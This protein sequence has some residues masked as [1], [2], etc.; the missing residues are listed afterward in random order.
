[1]ARRP[2]APLEPGWVVVGGLPVYHRAFVHPSAEAVPIVHVH[3]FGISGTYLEPTA[4]LLA[5]HHSCY[6]PDLPGMGRSLRPEQRLDLPG[7][8][9]A[10]VAYCDALGIDRAV[11][12]G[13]SLGCCLPA[14]AVPGDDAL[15]HARAPS[16]LCAPT[17]VIAGRRDPLVRLERASIFEGLPDVHC[18]A[19]PGAHALNYSAPDLVAELVEAFLRGEP[20]A[21]PT[22]VRSEVEVLAVG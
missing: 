2:V 5:A 10:I 9:R 19:V 16:P 18:I 14:L 7:L 20:L 4:A 13:T 21:T 1:M 8:S 17:L 12:V 11:F 6:V 3:G 22:G 15:P